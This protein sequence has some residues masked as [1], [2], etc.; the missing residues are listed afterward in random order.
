MFEW[1]KEELAAIKTPKFHLVEGPA[2]DELREVVLSST[3]P[4]SNAYKEFVLQFGNAKFFREL[5]NYQLHVFAGPRE[6]VWKKSGEDLIF[7]GFRDQ[8]KA[9]FKK[10]LL[11]EGI[12]PCV[13]VKC[14]GGLRQI[15]AN[16]EDW[17]KRNFK[18][19]RRHYKK[20]EW[21]RILEGPEPFSDAEK[22]ILEARKKFH[23]RV[24]GVDANG[25]MQF[26]V[27]NRSGRFLSYLS[28]GIRHKGGKLQGG[29]SL[30]VGH[31]AP[32]RVATVATDCYKKYYPA[33]EMEAFE[34]PDPGP[35]DRERYWEFRTNG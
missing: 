30:R 10:A 11:V 13:F 25:D 7:F 21:A 27:E 24:V 16:F 29:V 34:K 12:E 15:D 1:L 5:S 19:A 31:I 20:D 9:Y 23:W 35:D 26:E 14:G 6:A 4:I 17:L 22:D 8:A 33:G 2:S 32:G 18:V 3:L 28:I